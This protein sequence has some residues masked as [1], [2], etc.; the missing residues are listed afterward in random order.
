MAAKKCV[1]FLLKGTLLLLPILIMGYQGC[2]NGFIT[3]SSDDLLLS[4]GPSVVIDLNL[5][6]KLN[7]DEIAVG[8]G[9]PVVSQITYS[10]KPTVTKSIKTVKGFKGA[11]AISTPAGACLVTR[12]GQEESPENAEFNLFCSVSAVATVVF[13]I[14]YE[15]GSIESGDSAGT[16]II[17]AK[18][19]N[20][21]RSVGADL[22]NK[23]CTT[24][25]HGAVTSS[26]KAGKTPD[27]IFA[28]IGPAGT[29]KY[30]GMGSSTLMALTGTE[31]R[32][33][34]AALSPGGASDET[35]PTANV[36]SPTEGNTVS[37]V[38]LLT[39]NAQ[40][41]VGVTSVQFFV[42]GVAVGS[43]DNS[44]PYEA[45]LDTAASSFMNGNHIVVVKA[46][47]AAGNL[48]LSAPVSFKSQ[49]GGG[50]N[51]A[52]LYQDN[53]C[54]GCHGAIV[55]STVRGK[56]RAQL[57]ASIL[58]DNPMKKYSKLTSEERDALVAALK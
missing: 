49:N 54:A 38:V 14:E 12:V 42:D 2:G 50:F 11:H 25:C 30:P 7:D 1:G 41:N 31:I 23:T 10:F 4:F 47:D 27:E 13:E 48:G 29:P 43:E 16:V 17:T 18:S 8:E 22:Y 3:E 15:D 55:S 52:Q 9:L 37:G 40:D 24:S 26:S 19:K 53:G 44:A 20:E 56:T 32:A 5:K 28:A 58:N 46:K 36:T 51:G 33:I 6:D 34:S 35:P 21:L 45:S 57:D 39:A